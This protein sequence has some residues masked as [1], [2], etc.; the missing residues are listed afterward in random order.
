MRPAPASA[1]TAVITCTTLATAWPSPS[2]PP[3]GSPARLAL[4]RDRSCS[5][6]RSRARGRC[7]ARRALRRVPLWLDPHRCARPVSRRRSLDRSDSNPRRLTPTASPADAPLTDPEPSGTAATIR[8]CRSSPLQTQRPAVVGGPRDRSAVR[9]GRPGAVDPSPRARRDR[10]LRGVGSSNSQPGPISAPLAVLGAGIDTWS[11]CWYLDPDGDAARALRSRAVVASARGSWLLPEPIEGYRV[12]WFAGAHL[13]FAEGHLA[14]PDHLGCPAAL[15]AALSALE[16][17]IEGHGVPLPRRPSRVAWNPRERLPGFAGVRRLDTAID[18]ATGSTQSGLAL[19]E[20]VARVEPPRSKSSVR[21]AHGLV[22]TVEWHGY[23]G[24]WMV[25]RVYD[26]GLKHGTARR[27]QVLRLEDQRRFQAA[28]R[29]PVEALGPAQVHQ[30]VGRRFYPLVQASDVTIGD[31][32]VLVE[33]IRELRESGE[34][35]TKRAI[36]LVGA[37]LLDVAGSPP[38]SRSTYYRHRKQLRELGLVLAHRITVDGQV[39][40][41]DRVDVAL[42][43]VFDGVLGAG[44]WAELHA[45]AA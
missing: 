3:A 9:P 21:R 34:I 10:S 5:D 24:G 43:R 41:G 4:G 39:V 29:R 19:L 16:E 11:P 27:G 25:A 38:Q 15:P 14:G 26:K 17:A 13:A 40:Q 31:L 22:E 2:G 7:E 12:G 32:N 42:G 20:A 1:R 36:A 33:R 44:A 45:A 30:F 37:L 35:P 6:P 28:T 8:P 23:A 18:V